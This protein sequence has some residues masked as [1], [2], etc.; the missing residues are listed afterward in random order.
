[1]WYTEVGICEIIGRIG[2]SW[3]WVFILLYIL[4]GL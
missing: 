3:L 2:L 4:P 1:M